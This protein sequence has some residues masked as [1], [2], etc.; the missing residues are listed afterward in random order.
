MGQPIPEVATR[1]NN[2][3]LLL[4]ETNRLEEAEPLYRRALAIDEAAYGATHPRVATR[5]NNLALL[6]QETN[7]L[8]EAEPLYR[9]ALEIDEAAYGATHPRVATDLNNL[10]VLLR[11]T[12][13]LEEAEPLYRRALAIDEAAYGATHPEGGD[14]TSTTWRC[15]CKRPTGWRKPSRSIG[16]PWTIDEAA[17]GA[18]HPRVATHLNNLALLLRETNRLEEAEPLYRRALA[19][20]EAAYGATHPRVATDLNNLA[21]LLQATNRLEEAEP[22]YRR[23]VSIFKH[24][25]DSTGHEH[26]H[27]QTALANYS[28]LLQAM[29]LP[30]EDIARRLQ[31]IAGTPLPA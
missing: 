6:L 19:I 9:R 18:T 21:L 16:V 27:W 26:P 22:L 5:L 2:L 23:M 1:L 31:D 17:Y 12:N 24:F 3:A 7:R 13:R 20:D 15:C 4:Q 28:G 8:E 30:Q 14:A 10:A 25:N 29:G 11:E